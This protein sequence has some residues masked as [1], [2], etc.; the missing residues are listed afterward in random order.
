MDTIKMFLGIFKN[1]IR[2]K[3]ILTNTVLKMKDI[4]EL[5]PEKFNTQR[6]LTL[7]IA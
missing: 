3:H 6:Y 4:P 2:I 5:L 7:D 1:F